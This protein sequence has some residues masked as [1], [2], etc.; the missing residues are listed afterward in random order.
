MKKTPLIGLIAALSL[1]FT[2]CD[3]KNDLPDNGLSGR[4]VSVRIRSLR[5]FEGGSENRTRSSLEKEPEMISQPIGD[6]LLLEM[7]IKQEESPLRA[8]QLLG[9]GKLFRVIAVEHGTNDYYSHGDFT[10]G[11]S[12]PSTDFHVKVGEKY[13]YICISY[14]SDTDLP[15]D[16]DYEA[17]EALEES[18]EVDNTND[19]L[20]CRINKAE[21][22]PSTGVELDILLKQKLAKVTVIV[23]CDYN[24]WKITSITNGTVGIMGTPLTCSIDWSDGTLTGTATDQWLTFTSPTVPY[25][26]E[27]TSNELRVI[28]TTG[29]A[30]ITLE[31]DAISRDGFV[32]AVPSVPKSFPYILPLSGGVSYTITVRLRAPIFARSNIYWDNSTHKLTFVPAAIPPAINDDSK[33]G[34]QGLF[35]KWGSLVGIPPTVNWNTN[36]GVYKAGSTGTSTYTDWDLIPYETTNVM[37]DPDVST[38]KGDICKYIN[39]DYRIP[40]NGEFGV[41][42]GWNQA[43]EKYLGTDPSFRTNKVDGTYDFVAYGVG[44]AKN[45]VLDNVIFPASGH[46]INGLINNNVAAQGYYWSSSTRVGYTGMCYKLYFSESTFTPSNSS[47]GVL[48][49]SIRCVK[50]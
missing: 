29:Y 26:T 9:N 5:V 47:L 1:I 15:P 45:N 16:D 30:T 37:G 22:V 44:Y 6:G 35:F 39:P 31:I 49:H 27:L 20:W 34:Y 11:I 28:P 14:N 19:L 41:N 8:P 21:E 32:A 2:A 13:D 40:V 7:S 48:G 25:P 17:G 18:F 46:L 50:N 10:V 43:W 24:K 42:N 38:L 12:G 36:T 3:D 23:S 33:Q 4:E